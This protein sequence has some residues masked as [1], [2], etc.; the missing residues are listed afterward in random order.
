MEEV[1]GV[2]RVGEVVSVEWV[3]V[4]LGLRRVVVVEVLDVEGFLVA[5]L[6]IKLEWVV[7]VGNKLLGSWFF[8]GRGLSRKRKTESK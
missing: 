7:G 2:E 5:G 8:F 1:V 6:D 4:E 3:E